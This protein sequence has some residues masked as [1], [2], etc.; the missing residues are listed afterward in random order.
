MNELVS[1]ATQQGV[2]VIQIDNPPVNALTPGLPE[3]L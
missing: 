3:A 1:T 2:A